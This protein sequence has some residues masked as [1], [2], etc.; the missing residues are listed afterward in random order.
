MAASMT[1][2]SQ[3]AVNYRHGGNWQGQCGKCNMYR[4]NSGGQYGRCTAV[5]GKITPFGVCDLFATT[6]NPFGERPVNEQIGH[7]HNRIGYL[8]TR[9]A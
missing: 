6:G 5:N 1:R 4:K 8:R 9:L 7:L 3:A 2:A